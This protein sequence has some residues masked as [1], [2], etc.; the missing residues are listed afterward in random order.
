MSRLRNRYAM[1]EK[2]NGFV[3]EKTVRTYTKSEAR[4]VFKKLL[5]LPRRTRLSSQQV[6]IEVS[7]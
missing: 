2:S 7:V 5:R 6:V 4:A 3:Y 1:V